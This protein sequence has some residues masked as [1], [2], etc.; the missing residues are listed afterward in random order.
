MTLTLLIQKIERQAGARP[1]AF[2]EEALPG[3]GDIRLL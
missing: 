2:D 1:I 3:E